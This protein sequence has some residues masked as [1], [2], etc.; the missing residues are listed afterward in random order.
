MFKRYLEKETAGCLMS[1]HR[2]RVPVSDHVCC[3][4]L[5]FSSETKSFV[6]FWKYSYRSFFLKLAALFYYFDIKIHCLRNCF[7]FV[8]FFV[9][10]LHL[11]SNYWCLT[12]VHSIEKN[13]SCWWT[14]TTVQ[15]FVSTF[16]LKQNV[17]SVSR[18]CWLIKFLI[19][20]DQRKLKL[21]KKRKMQ[22]CV[23]LVENSSVLLLVVYVIFP[24][25]KYQKYKFK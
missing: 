25:P 3:A 6:A 13:Q 4:H 7:S 5:V 1:S 15:W 11:F 21:K 9:K 19:F 22:L 23:H 16:A 12:F 24:I 18:C 8:L 14:G 10:Q 2:S 20:T 17:L